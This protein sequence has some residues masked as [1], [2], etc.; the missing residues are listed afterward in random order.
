MPGQEIPDGVLTTPKPRLTTVSG[1][2]PAVAGVWPKAY[3]TRAADRSARR[4][5]SA[6]APRQAPV[7]APSAP[8][9]PGLG[10]RRTTVPC[11][12]L[13]SQFS[14]GLN[15]EQAMPLGALTT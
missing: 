10:V 5:P 4:Q 14:P 3:P 11:P 13:A 8:P 2:L 1:A 6:G 15:E 7:H 9:A 12:K